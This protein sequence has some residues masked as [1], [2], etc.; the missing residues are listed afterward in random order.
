MIPS[1]SGPSRAAQGIVLT[2]TPLRV[3]FAGGGT[4][5]AAFYEHDDGAVFS[6]T[7]DKYVYV[8]VKR[9]GPVFDEKI[10][11]NYSVSESV[12]EVDAIRNDIA[13]ESLR[14]LDID[15]PI[16]ISVVSDLPDSS[17]LGG[18]SAFAVGL[19]HALHLYK[20]ERPSAEQLAEEASEIEI[21]VLA[22]PIG[23]QDQYAAA[24]GGLNLLSFRADAS[25]VATPL[26]AAP[27][28]IEGLFARLIML[29]TGHQRRSSSVLFE[30]RDRTPDHRHQLRHMRDQAYELQ[31]IMQDPVP[32]YRR[33]AALL[34]SGWTLKRQLAGA[35]SNDLIDAWYRAALEAGAEGGKLCGAGGG[36]FL[37]FMCDPGRRDAIEQSMPDLRAVPIAY[38]PRGTRVLLAQAD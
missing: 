34:R 15:P 17:G 14:L 24:I 31:Q 18:S 16:Y 28:A 2:Q 37:L 13:R 6:T 27:D 32:D 1:H 19:L 7:I 21:G 30:Q 25:V 9:H 11:L 35:V 10:R 36:G 22:Q 5:L 20:G 26:R 12:G 8:T 29:W 33:F 3:S 23:K 38:E 4:D